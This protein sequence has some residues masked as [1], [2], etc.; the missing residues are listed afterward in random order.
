MYGIDEEK[1]WVIPNGV[2]L[3]SVT[4]CPWRER[5]IAKQR[6]GI[7]GAFVGLFTG[8]WHGPNVDALL[9]ILELAARLPEVSFLVMGSV[10]QAI[11]QAEDL[12]ELAA[13]VIS[14]WHRCHPHRPADQPR[15][16]E[17]SS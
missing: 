12:E 8:S 9:F 13:L 5:A 6:L 7:G 10:G 15:D 3:E 4:F 11:H 17:A 14:A 2:D 16:P 1:I